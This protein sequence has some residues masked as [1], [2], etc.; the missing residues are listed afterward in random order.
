M[1]LLAVLAIALAIQQ[2]ISFS[3]HVPL[4]VDEKMLII[5]MQRMH[6][7]PVHFIGYGWGENVLL[8]YAARPFVALGFDPLNVIRA[9]VSLASIATLLMTAYLARHWFGD[10][11]ALVSLFN[12]A[13]WPWSVASGGVGFNVFLALPLFIGAIIL[14]AQYLRSGRRLLPYIAGA[15]IGIASY[16]YA[17]VLVWALFFF[18]GSLFVSL[19]HKRIKGWSQMFGV[20]GLIALPMILFYAKNSFG[21]PLPDTFWLLQFPTLTASRFANIVV[22][23]SLFQKIGACTWNYISHFN[24]F[25]LAIAL[26]SHRYGSYFAYAWDPFLIYIALWQLLATRKMPLTLAWWLCLYPIGSSL[27]RVDGIFALTRDVIG[28]PAL[29]IVSSFGL[30]FVVSITCSYLRRYLPERVLT[31]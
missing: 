21:L 31:F 29:I 2:R 25:L 20:A 26:F 8:A 13:L 16:G 12:G 4:N 7:L 5:E 17:I 10:T 3:T 19:R 14:F 22:A 15:C 18:I 6:G 28:M 11:V 30:V 1:L 24:F 9:I 23:G 27:T